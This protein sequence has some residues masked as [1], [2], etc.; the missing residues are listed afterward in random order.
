M[1]KATIE[2]IY[3]NVI[4]KKII[5]MAID[6]KLPMDMTE[7]NFG[8]FEDEVND[9]L[10]ENENEL[11]YEKAEEFLYLD[12]ITAEEVV[13]YIVNGDAKDDDVLDFV[14]PKDAYPLERYE[15]TFTVVSFLDTIGYNTLKS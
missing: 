8:Y 2:Q 12:G 13:E 1:K 10:K 6:D 3:D 4:H 14:L 5:Q 7:L 9:Y 15:H 11:A